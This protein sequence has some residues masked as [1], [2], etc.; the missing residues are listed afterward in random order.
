[1]VHLLNYYEKISKFISVDEENILITSGIDGGIKS[2]FE[3]STKANDTVGVVQPTYAM[4]QVYSKIF[5]T[6]PFE[7]DFEEDLKFN[8]LKFEKFLETKPKVFFLPNPNQPIE[9]Y[10]NTTQLSD[11]A[12]KLEEDAISE[13]CSL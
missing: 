2:V 9:S 3:I 13:D 4:Y 6:K 1:M 8:Y 7:I 12:K 11:F 5:R 10:F